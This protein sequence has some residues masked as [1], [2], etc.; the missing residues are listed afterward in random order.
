MLLCFFYDCNLCSHCIDRIDYIVIVLPRELIYIVTKDKL[1]E[2]VDF[3]LWIYRSYA[4]PHNLNLWSADCAMQRD[5]LSIYVCHIDY[6]F[7]DDSDASD[8]G[9]S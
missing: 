7:V 3:A 5:N 6:I 8:S 1:L 2:H 4:L 9:S